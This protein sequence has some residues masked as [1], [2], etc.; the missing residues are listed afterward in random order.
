M[1]SENRNRALK[2]A[3]E[4]WPSGC[5]CVVFDCCLGLLQLFDKRVARIFITSCEGRV[6]LRCSLLDDEV[7][8]G[9]G[10]V[11]QPQ[12]AVEGDDAE[13]PDRQL[14]APS[15]VRPHHDDLQPVAV[16]RAGHV[17]VLPRV[18]PAQGTIP[19]LN[20][21]RTEGEGGGVGQNVT[22]V[23]IGCVNGT[24][25]RGE[26]VQKSEIFVDVI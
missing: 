6:C 8:V 15:G 3:T 23:L 14:V 16:R 21:V 4:E 2:P 19:N 1:S 22:I 9:V 7:S 12:V 18:G 5:V 13:D 25:T 20:D 26:G 24:V 17:P 10:G 11:L